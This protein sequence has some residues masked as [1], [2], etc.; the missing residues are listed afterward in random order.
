MEILHL[1]VYLLLDKQLA[2]TGHLQLGAPSVLKIEGIKC[3]K[4]RRP[5]NTTLDTL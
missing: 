1:H 2:T 4:Y 5:C 3:D